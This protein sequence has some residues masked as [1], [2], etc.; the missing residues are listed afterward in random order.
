M[1]RNNLKRQA[2]SIAT[3]S[4]LVAACAGPAVYEPAAG[5][6][7]STITFDRGDA[8]AMALT[9]YSNGGNCTEKRTLPGGSAFWDGK[10]IS[11]EAGREYA[12]GMFTITDSS[13]GWMTAPLGFVTLSSTTCDMQILSFRPQANARYKLSYR[14]DPG[15][16]RC[17]TSLTRVGFDGREAPEPSF[18]QRQPIK[19]DGSGAAECA[20]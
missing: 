8:K 6:S 2:T 19:T 16:K 17:T 4:L 14:T 20:P 3:A 5:A 12:F 15:Q 13:V 1:G 11:L 7:V 10:P 18:R 9:F